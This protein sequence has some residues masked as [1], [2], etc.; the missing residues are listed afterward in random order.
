MQNQMIVMTIR[1]KLIG[2][3]IVLMGLVSSCAIPGMTTEEVTT[4]TAEGYQPTKEEYYEQV[5]ADGGNPVLIYN[6]QVDKKMYVGLSNPVHVLVDGDDASHLS[7]YANGGKLDTV[8][9]AK[10]IYNLRDAQPGFAVEVAAKNMK[11]GKTASQFFDVIPVPAPLAIIGKYRGNY[12]KTPLLFTAETIKEQTAIVLYHEDKLPV[13]CAAT[14]YKVTRVDGEG[15]RETVENVSRGGMFADASQA[16][17]SKAK[18]GDLYIISN[19][20]T[21]CSSEKIKNIVYEIQ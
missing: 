2:N 4:E 21:A 3:F 17:I 7:V 5:A 10:G 19:I 14:S 18:K 16:L 1:K 13:R 12:K 6:G 15:N 20:K 9:K 8:D 11:T